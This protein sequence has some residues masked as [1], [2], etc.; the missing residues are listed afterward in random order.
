MH[1]QVSITVS[2]VGIQASGSLGLHGASRR[3]FLFVVQQ[4]LTGIAKHGGRRSNQF[5]LISGN[6]YRWW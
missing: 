1:M 3:N 5:P 6:I 4:D 2:V